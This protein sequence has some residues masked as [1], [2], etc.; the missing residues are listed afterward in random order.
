MKSLSIEKDYILNESKVFRQKTE[1]SAKQISDMQ[2][3][4][5]SMN[6]RV[7]HIEQG[8]VQL[9]TKNKELSKQLKRAEVVAANIETQLRD[10]FPNVRVEYVRVQDAEPSVQLI[11]ALCSNVSL[12]DCEP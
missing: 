11:S 5:N 1:D 9:E 6:R 3:Q 10:L 7:A 2:S 8:K 12:F 4:L